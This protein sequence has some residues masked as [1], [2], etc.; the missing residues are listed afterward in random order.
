MYSRPTPKIRKSALPTSKRS[1]TLTSRG[2]ACA[3]GQKECH[4]RFVDGNKPLRSQC[5][6]SDG[7]GSVSPSMDQGRLCHE[8][9][10]DSADLF[11]HSTCVDCRQLPLIYILVVS[12]L[13]VN[14]SVTCPTHL[15][16][17]TTESVGV[18]KSEVKAKSGAFRCKV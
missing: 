17:R 4:D 7:V 15:E 10:V 16:T 18:M 1:P 2:V 12:G 13:V 5:S 11:V 14:W 9:S 3:Y 8:V 6:S